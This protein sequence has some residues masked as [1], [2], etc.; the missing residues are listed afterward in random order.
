MKGDRESNGLVENAVVLL[1]VIIRTIKCHIESRTREPLS[2]ES[3]VVPWLVEHAG[4]I[5]S[6]CE[7]GRDGRTPLKRLHGKK[8]TQEFVP[9]GEKVLGTGRTPD[10][11]TGVGLGCET[12]AQTGVLWRMTD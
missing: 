7:K 10:I 9:F 5:L 2:D 11:S 4:C 8:Q 1:R 6:R 12:T 3:P